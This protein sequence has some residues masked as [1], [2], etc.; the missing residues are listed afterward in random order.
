MSENKD[1]Y[2][3]NLP[4]EQIEKLILTNINN[5]CINICYFIQSGNEVNLLT[6]IN[7]T[8]IIYELLTNDFDFNKNITQNVETKNAVLLNSNSLDIFKLLDKKIDGD[9][10]LFW[11][12]GMLDEKYQPYI[13][14]VLNR[15][16][17]NNF[18]LEE[19]KKIITY[20]I[21]KDF[22]LFNEWFQE[23]IVFT[24]AI[25]NNRR[26]GCSSF[27]SYDKSI[28]SY[29][30]LDKIKILEECFNIALI[31][32]EKDFIKKNV[33]KSDNNSIIKKRI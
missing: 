26:S 25:K 8:N 21:G 29:Y 7:Q 2:I 4:M 12:Y 13:L 10:F 24:D 11:S 1:V 6:I 19:Q 33:F 14:S 17:D 15:K 18:K 31:S 9:L 16:L 32:Y 20:I 5:K 30:S 22:N 27:I 28:L 23:R 3:D